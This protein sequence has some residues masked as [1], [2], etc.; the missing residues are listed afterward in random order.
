M[1]KK[2]NH[3][4]TA[5]IPEAVETSVFPSFSQTD[6]HVLNCGW[7]PCHLFPSSKGT[8]LSKKQVVY[9]DSSFMSPIQLLM[10]LNRRMSD[11]DK[12]IDFFSGNTGV[13]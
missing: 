8:E 9:M 13:C 12:L 11:C 7:G 5:D 10:S 3:F 1:E 2:T 6:V 4:M